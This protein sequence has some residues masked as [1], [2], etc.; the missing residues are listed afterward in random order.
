MNPRRLK[1]LSNPEISTLYDL[2]QFTCEEQQNYYTLNKKEYKV[3][4]ARGSL[5]SRV[6]FI[7]QLGYFKASSQFFTCTFEQAQ[8]DVTFILNEYFSGTRLESQ[9]VSKQTRHYNQDQIAKLLKF[10]A[11][12]TIIKTKLLRLLDI[13][14]RICG[15]PVYLFH[16][17]LIYS[18]QHKLMLLGYSTLQDLIGAAITQE[19]SRLRKLLKK[20]VPLD[21]YKT[22]GNLLTIE[23]REYLLTALKKDPKSFSYT[24]I[25]GEVEKLRDQK[26]LYQ[27][28]KSVLPKLNI[29][30]QN[31]SYYARL[32]IHYP[33]NQIKEL[34]RTMRVVYIL[35]YVH[36]R[37][38]KIHDNL[39]VSHF[40]YVSKIQA[41]AKI[42]ACEQILNQKLEM[43]K[44]AKQAATV[45]R[46]F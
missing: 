26:G 14:L 40:H 34:S 24:Q 3:M 30:N 41:E 23:D 42:K 45:L 10:C 4:T 19:E 38:Q 16:E 21:M 31:I 27:S 46:F 39:M 36:H 43:G 5:A 12:K 11:N 6:H 9:F 2:P 20:H 1:I 7:L 8:R 17:L 35:C 25:R 15:D 18:S 29:S 28:A 32:A 33:I 22:I 44:D 37:Y 13:K